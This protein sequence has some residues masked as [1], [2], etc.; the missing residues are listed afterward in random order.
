VRFTDRTGPATRIKLMTDGILLAELARDRKLERY[1]TLILDEAHERSLNIDFL[2]GF[3]R[4]LLPQRPDLKLIIASATLDPEKLARHFEGAPIIEVA[5][6]GFPIELRYR[7]APAGEE[8]DPYRALVA[9]IDEA[10]ASVQ[11]RQGD[12]LVFL[13]GEREIREA[14]Q[15][16]RRASARRRRGAARCTRAV[17]GGSGSRVRARRAPGRVVLATNVA[18][19][20][21]TV[22]GVTAVVDTGLARLSRY[23]HR[24]KIQR[25]PI[26]PVSRASADQRMGR[27]GRV[28]PGLCIRL[29]DEADYEARPAFTDPEIL[30][31]NLASVILRMAELG[32]GDIEEFPFPTRRTRSS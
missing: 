28:A 18:E 14:A 25:L 26:E 12:T 23:G 20:S 2:L 31:T 15:A 29:Y 4:G 3:L 27:C 7:P 19:T 21:L 13:P 16:L 6:R 22:P 30:R 24:S 8:A 10:A 5:G 11:G 1:E 9:A 32:L 17:G